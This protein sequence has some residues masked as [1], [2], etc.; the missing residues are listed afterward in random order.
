MPPPVAVALAVEPVVLGP[1]RTFGRYAGADQPMAIAVAVKARAWRMFVPSE[2]GWE[3]NAL[4]HSIGT[5]KAVR[6]VRA[7]HR[8]EARHIA[9]PFSN[10]EPHA[11]TTNSARRPEVT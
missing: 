3:G 5:H 7:Q 8:F 10:Q 9:V 11:V 2:D 1:R 6:F 4:R